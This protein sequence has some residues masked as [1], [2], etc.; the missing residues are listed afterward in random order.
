MSGEPE[1]TITLQS[2]DGQFFRRINPDGSFESKYLGL[3]WHPHD[4]VFIERKQVPTYVGTMVKNL[5]W[6]VRYSI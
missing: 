5:K 3:E 2:P 4:P 1:Q 6:K